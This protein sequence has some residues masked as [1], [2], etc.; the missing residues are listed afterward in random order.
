M[1]VLFKFRD[2]TKLNLLMPGGKKKVSHT[3]LKFKYVCPF[4]Y[5]QAL[6]G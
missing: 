5:L 2:Y 3:H 4:C 1:F 6:K